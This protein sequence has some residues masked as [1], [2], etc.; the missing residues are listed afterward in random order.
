MI[1][2][3]YALLMLITPLP[4]AETGII[5]VATLPIPTMAQIEPATAPISEID[6]VEENA[7]ES[8]L[9]ELSASPTITDSAPISSESISPEQALN[10]LFTTGKIQE[11]WFVSDF[12]QEI[13]LPQIESAITQLSRGLGALQAV[14]ATEEGYEINFLRGTVPAQ[15]RLTASGQ[16]AGL[17]FDPPLIPI[18]IEEAIAVLET[19]PYDTSLLVTKDG[20]DLGSINSETPLAVAS[21][22]KLAVLAAL[23]Q[24]IDS[25]ALAWN[26]VIE[27]QPEWKS[28]PSGIMQEWPDGSKVT[29]DTLA[30]L[31]ISISDNTATDA[32]IRTL[33]RE[34]IEQ[35][36]QQNQPFITTKE[37]FTLKNPDNQEWLKRYKDGDAVAK[38]QVLDEL[39]D[40]PLPNKNLFAGDPVDIEIE[41]LFSA[42]DLCSL[43][44]SVADLPTMQINPGVANP[45]QWEQVAFKGGA[46]PGV[47]NLTTQL[48]NDAGETY[49]I[50]S[51]WNSAD[52]ELNEE[53]LTEIYRGV[54]IGLS[55][56]S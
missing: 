33:G 22:F 10:R 36:S 14:Q 39:G 47:L 6:T 4:W 35:L 50:S 56:A 31:M 1:A 17:F 52:Q 29:V 48:R 46:E 38:Q 15:I 37:L 9:S 13:P 49:C 45:R 5:P 7:V 55:S 23:K 32:L 41:W 12:L 43:M 25:G 2:F 53:R 26:T 3:A 34:K 16:I 20:V 54:I 24:Q 21:S 27:L 51:T 44:Q 40:R 28:L 30:T 11:E 19:A 8:D 18:G 42:R